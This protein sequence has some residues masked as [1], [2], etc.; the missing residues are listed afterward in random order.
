M[1]STP[2]KSLHVSRMAESLIGSEIIKLAGEVRARMARGEQVYN[3]TIGDFDPAVF[4]IP[5]GLL[6]GIIEAYRQGET[7]YPPANGVAILRDAVS[8]FLARRQGLTYDSES[9][10]ISAGARPIIYAIYRTLID[11][12]DRIVY[13]VPSWNNNHYTHLSSGK[14]IALQ[15]RPQD[16][17]MPTAE[18]L[19]PHLKGATLL[20]L[21]SPLNPTGTAF[22][23][24][25]LAQICDLV[26]EENAR[27][28]PQQK[29][30]YVIYDQIYWTLTFGETRHA[31]PVSLRPEMRDYTIYVDGISKAFAAT[32]V[33]VGWGFGPA[34]IIAKMRA[35]LSHVGAWSP[36]AEQVGTAHYLGNDQVVDRDI[37]TM[38]S[39]VESRLTAL[40]KG[41][42]RLERAGYPVGAIAPQGAI[43]LTLRFDL[44]GRTTASGE[45]LQT[46]SDV[47][48]F[49][50]EEAKLA[51]VPF[52]AFGAPADS[53]WYRLSVGTLQ[54]EEV[55]QILEHVEMALNQL[56]G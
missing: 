34:P 9:I 51:V 11:D 14:G 28:S 18:L 24:E 25:G 56:K 33:R 52:T 21:C 39:A 6:E 55:D 54:L 26:L 15:T 36:K 7:N 2:V 37:E 35:I 48:R 3:L 42:D 10:L 8:A 29:P 43:Y 20:A 17:F 40:Y 16:G 1:E 32:G 44:V 4:P 50:L 49:L 47:T 19:K 41:F 22:H 46:M 12:G 13:P 23:P 27:R 31:D 5:N 45:S 38:K 30:L 53:P